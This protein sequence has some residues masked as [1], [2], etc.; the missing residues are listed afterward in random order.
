MM[1]SLM[2]VPGNDR[3]LGVVDLRSTARHAHAIGRYDAL[4]PGLQMVSTSLRAKSVEVLIEGKG[5]FTGPAL[6]S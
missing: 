6:D 2:S 5:W 4:N 1:S 3:F